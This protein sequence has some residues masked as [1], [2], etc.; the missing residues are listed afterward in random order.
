M[1]A[2]SGPLK[3]T[4]LRD[5]NLVLCLPDEISGRF[6]RNKTPI[7]LTPM[8]IAQLNTQT[9]WKDIDDAI[10]K[11]DFDKDNSL[12]VGIAKFICGM[13]TINKINHIYFGANNDFL[14]SSADEMVQFWN[15]GVNKDQN[16]ISLS[17]YFGLP[18]DAHLNIEGVLSNAKNKMG[19]FLLYTSTDSE[20]LHPLINMNID[21]I[22]SHHNGLQFGDE[23]AVLSLANFHRFLQIMPSIL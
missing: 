6:G 4:G 8:D 18:R 16:D 5:N 9:Y 19:I 13:Q 11:F 2:N 3:E 14:L 21:P 1:F 23:N 12:A 22:D 10:N 15:E 20:E 17:R 7:L